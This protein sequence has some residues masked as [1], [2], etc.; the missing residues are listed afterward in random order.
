MRKNKLLSLTNSAENFEK[1]IA[2]Y[3]FTLKENYD[4]YKDYDVYI[5]YG[6][7]LP[8]KEK[9]QNAH[10]T[11]GFYCENYSDLDLFRYLDQKHLMELKN[12]IINFLV[13]QRIIPERVAQKLSF[14]DKRY[15]NFI[16]NLPFEYLYPNHTQKI[17]SIAKEKINANFVPLFFEE[18]YLEL[19]FDINNNRE[20][21][22]IYSLEYN[23]KI[24]KYYLNYRSNKS[25]AHFCNMLKQKPV[26]SGNSAFLL[27]QIMRFIKIGNY[28]IGY[29]PHSKDIRRNREYVLNKMLAKYKSI[30]EPKNKKINELFSIQDVTLSTEIKANKVYTVAYLEFLHKFVN[31]QH[32]NDINED[33]WNER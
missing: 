30:V 16:K 31:K 24:G 1:A 23:G 4:F 7:N 17:L 8:K 9:D 10:G 2:L 14:D 26:L 5:Y 21:Y 27:E 33:W 22:S 19:L 32:F 28:T 18:N 12:Q 3:Y 29:R 20:K 6:H 15:W 11:I 13:T 25:F